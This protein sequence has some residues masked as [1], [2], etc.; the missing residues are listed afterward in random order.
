MKKIFLF[1]LIF[2]F[3]ANKLLADNSCQEGK[4]PCAEEYYEPC[5]TN[6]G[7]SGSRFCRFFGCNDTGTAGTLCPWGEGSYCETCTPTGQT[8]PTPT[9][10]L[11]CTLSSG[12][13]AGRCTVS[14]GIC[15]PLCY[16]DWSASPND[17]SDCKQVSCA[18]GNSTVTCCKLPTNPTN[19]P[20]N[21]PNQPTNP[22][23]QPTNPPNQ[24]TNPR[25]QPTPPLPSNTPPTIPP[26]TPTPTVIYITQ[27]PGSNSS[28][29]IKN[30]YYWNCLKADYYNGEINQDQATQTIYND[31]RLK[32]TGQLSKIPDQLYIVS[33]LEVNSNL[34]CQSG[35]NNVDNLLG[36][37]SYNG[38]DFKLLNPRSNPFSF[39][40]NEIE[41]SDNVVVYSK[42]N[43]PLTHQFYAVYLATNRSEVGQGGLQQATDREGI[44]S[45]ECRFIRWD[46]IVLVLEY[47]NL[48]PIANVPV[49]LKRKDDLNLP[50]VLTNNS[51]VS[52]K[53]GLIN[54]HAIDGKYQLDIEI[55]DGYQL[56][57]KPNEKLSKNLIK[58]NILYNNEGEIIIPEDNDKKILILL[59]KVNPMLHF[60][61]KILLKLRKN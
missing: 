5:T 25:N 57:I 15:R 53:N 42:S 50:Q 54:F 20:T 8:T 44:L 49:T 28:P 61:K 3:L 34:Y 1:L 55:P 60:L 56:I 4:Q 14:N 23:N 52:D 41:P 36:I 10:P 22:P 37:R 16:N 58:D 26:P 29:I 47:P 24:R 32:L 35:S 19:Q 43:Q 13:E 6:S 40:K 39:S 45:S 27:S 33:C 11:W 31:H 38:H 2:L 17:S 59:E 18:C 12:E 46:P 7:Q 21:P 9:T 30:N 51:F 48:R